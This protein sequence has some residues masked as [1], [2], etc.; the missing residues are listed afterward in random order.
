MAAINGRTLRFLP[1]NGLKRTIIIK[2]RWYK[3]NY[4]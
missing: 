2:V 4:A 1:R 3:V